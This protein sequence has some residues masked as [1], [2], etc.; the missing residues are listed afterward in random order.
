ME[1]TT[2][3][4]KRDVTRGGRAKRQIFENDKFVSRVRT[5]DDSD[6]PREERIETKIDDEN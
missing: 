1:A 2:G 3:A 4:E 6:G 5:R